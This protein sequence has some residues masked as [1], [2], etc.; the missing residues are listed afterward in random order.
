[1]P[2]DLVT[3]SNRVPERKNATIPN[4]QSM[5]DVVALDG[6]WAAC[7]RV[8]PSASWTTAN[9][10]FMVSLDGGMSFGDLWKDGSEYTIT[11]GTG[12]TNATVFNVD[13]KDFSSVTHLRVRSGTA[14]T[15][16][17]QGAERIVQVGRMP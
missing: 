1:M 10:T 16:V 4:G 14:A 6:D 3:V 12:R 2:G 15:P 8:P 7:F 5:S 9:L 11:V 13:P 17:P